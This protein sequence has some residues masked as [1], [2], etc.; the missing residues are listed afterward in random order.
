MRNI[1][2]LGVTGSIGRSALN[3]YRN[4]KDELH[5]H[6]V[7]VNHS[8]QSMLSVL[9]QCHPEIAVVT[10]A[11]ACRAHFGASSAQY[12]DTVIVSGSEGLQQICSDRQSDIVL[13]AVAGQAGLLPS[14]WTLSSGTDLAL[15]NKE[16]MVCGGDILKKLSADNGGR[17]I[18]VDSEHSAIFQLLRDKN[19]SELSRI[20]ITASGG[21]FRQR[22]KAT[23]CDI[24]VEEA[25]SHPTWSMGRKISIDSATMANK[26]LEVIE[27][28]K[29]FDLDYDRISVLV[30]PQSLIHSMI[31]MADGEIYAQ[32]GPKDMSLPIQ[33]SLFYPDI[34]RNEYNRL[35][36]T[37]G[38]MLEMQPIDMDKFRM[39]AFAYE[40][41]R[42]G[43]LWTAFYNS[44][45]ECLV[46]KFLAGTIRFTDIESGMERALECFDADNAIDKSSVTLDNIDAVQKLAMQIV[47]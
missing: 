7:S 26:G 15:A 9:D 18:P 16:S 23:W 12:G 38:L 45:N 17:I 33:N 36:L 42:R 13:N 32:I 40:V 25:L 22:A 3:V 41:G 28:N 39:L 46:A 10:D 43:G 44:V 11:D 2:I 24:T 6:A 47:G 1:T 5:I 14:V 21:P 31:E 27:A 34:R 35:D 37:K 4:F 20:I 29:L 30:H 19:R 8:I